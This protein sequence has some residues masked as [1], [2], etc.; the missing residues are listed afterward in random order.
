MQ[1]AGCDHRSQATVGV[2][3]PLGESCKQR[4]FLSGTQ[5]S[6]TPTSGHWSTVSG[7]DASSRASEHCPDLG[8]CLELEAQGRLG[9]IQPALPTTGGCQHLASHTRGH[10]VAGDKR[11]ARHRIRERRRKMKR[12]AGFQQPDFQFCFCFLIA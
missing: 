8:P 11:E 1:G 9:L 2:L 4:C 3:L 7:W 6:L 12:W 5:R 10:P